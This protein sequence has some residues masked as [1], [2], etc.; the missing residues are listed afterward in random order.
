MSKYDGQCLNCGGA[1]EAGDLIVWRRGEGAV[2]RRCPDGIPVL[3]VPKAPRRFETSRAIV[4]VT[5]VDVKKL[6]QGKVAVYA[7]GEGNIVSSDFMDDEGRWWSI[8][9]IGNT[10]LRSPKVYPRDSLRHPAKMNPLWAQRMIQEYS[11]PGDAVLDPMAGGG[12]TGIE[13]SRLGRNATMVDLD[14]HWTKTMKRAVGRLRRSGQMRGSVRV[15]QGDAT[16]LDPGQ[17]FDAVMF[18]PPYAGTVA[19]KDH[20]V[21][22]SG[23]G[24][25]YH[26]QWMSASKDEFMPEVYERCRRLLEDGGTMIINI[27]DRVENGRLVDVETPTVRTVEGSGFRLI[28]KCNVR[29]PASHL[30]EYNERANPDMPHIR[31][32]TFLVFEK[33]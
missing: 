22:W 1:I 26:G 23:A 6:T 13:A 31:H 2:H 24:Q 12:T 9:R 17:R 18:S 14:P 33:A 8:P 10:K 27:K 16:K 32:E 20:P 21:S 7:D 25:D 15:L 4:P 5:R 19:L 3:K 29:A 28:R 11:K 30:R